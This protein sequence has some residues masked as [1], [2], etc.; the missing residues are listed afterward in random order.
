MA[1]SPARAAAA[2]Q[3]VVVEVAPAGSLQVAAFGDS[4]MWGQGNRRQDRFSALFTGRLRARVGQPGVLVW[5][6]SRSG[7][8]IGALPGER[9]S[10]VDAYPFLFPDAATRRAFLDDR[11][12]SRALGLY[13]EVP[14]TFPT[15][16][17]LYKTVWG[18]RTRPLVLTWA[19]M[20]PAHT[21]LMRPPR[22][23]QR[24]IRSWEKV[25][26][27]VWGAKTVPF[28]LTCSDGQRQRRAS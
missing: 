25:G 10:F 21:R 9:E 27:R 22:T 5:D 16:L 3:G 4:L 12:E 20:R 15:V 11:D 8:K 24:L 2:P 17:G 28:P 26:D 19:S 18:S 14:A 23:G 13:G 7:A 1:P 6:S